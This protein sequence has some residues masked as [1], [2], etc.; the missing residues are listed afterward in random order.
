[1]T[2]LVL[3]GV[4]RKMILKIK[5]QNTVPFNEHTLHTHCTEQKHMHWTC[6][7]FFAYDE[8]VLINFFF[9]QSPTLI[10]F[11]GAFIYLFI[12]S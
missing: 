8:Y 6:L 4:L 1:M 2:L 7:S 9:L 10:G 5:S 11:G 3:S 12:F